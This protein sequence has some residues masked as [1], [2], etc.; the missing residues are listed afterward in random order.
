MADYTE[1][2]AGSEGRLRSVLTL[3][4][5]LVVSAGILYLLLGRTDF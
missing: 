5:K 2:V 3:L 1:D 4:L